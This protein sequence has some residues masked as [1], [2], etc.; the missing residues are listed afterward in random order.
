[1]PKLTRAALHADGAGP[2]GG[3]L[4]PSEFGCS[5]NTSG[6]KFIPWVRQFDMFLSC[7]LLNES[8]NM[9]AENFYR[10]TGVIF[11]MSFLSK[12]GI[13]DA[14]LN[15]GACFDRQTFF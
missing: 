11:L 4:G 13:S 1:M 12:V 5:S 10:S 15:H 8:V 9:P 2:I 14:L 6:L 3:K 7:P